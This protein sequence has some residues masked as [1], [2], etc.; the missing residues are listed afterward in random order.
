MT[1]SV[2]AETNN[3]R[4]KTAKRVIENEKLEQRFHD[5]IVI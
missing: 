4:E 2:V 3:H 1:N 5:K